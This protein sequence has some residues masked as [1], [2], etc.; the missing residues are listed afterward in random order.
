[1][2]LSKAQQETYD[3]ILRQI[4]EARNTESFEEYF[5]KHNAPRKNSRYDT[6]EKCNAED[7][8]FLDYYKENYEQRKM[9]IALT[10]CAG[11]T[12]QKLQNLGLI[13]IIEDST[14]TRYGVDRV[15]AVF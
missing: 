3:D 11:A 8:R 15:R 12:I 7:P 13:E 2:K 9:G 5:E 14:G 6:I 4:S 1:M 10:H